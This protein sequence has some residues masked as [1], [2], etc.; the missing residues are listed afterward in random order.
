MLKEND[1]MF[2]LKAGWCLAPKLIVELDS[3]SVLLVLN[4]ELLPVFTLCPIGFWALLGVY[5]CG[6]YL[7]EEG[8]CMAYCR[9]VHG[10]E[11]LI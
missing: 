11:T 10:L 2:L 5:G 7:E 9:W 1:I 8:Y 3:N 6:S 4:S